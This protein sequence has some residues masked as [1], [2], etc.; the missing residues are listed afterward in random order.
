M[1]GNNM[2]ELTQSSVI[3]CSGDNKVT[4]SNVAH[5]Y[6]IQDD[7]IAKTTGGIKS[8]DI[9]FKDEERCK[10]IVE[11]FVAR[12]SEAMT[13]DKISGWSK[14]VGAIQDAVNKSHQKFVLDRIK[15]HS[16]EEIDAEYQGSYLQ[17]HSMLPDD[18]V[19]Q[20]SLTKAEKTRK[21]ALAQSEDEQAVTLL[22]L[23]KN[24]ANVAKL[25]ATDPDT[26]KALGLVK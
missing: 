22:A 9:D 11:V 2:A 7:G 10:A 23:L 4:L 12:F 17:K 26:A 1:K 8:I 15:T 20:K 25:I 16:E 5:C 19:M 24:P 3:T 18:A 13:D 14:V 6:E 21:E